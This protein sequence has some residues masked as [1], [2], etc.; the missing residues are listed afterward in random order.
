M[1]RTQVMEALKVKTRL[2][3]IAR[4]FTIGC[5]I[6]AAT[7]LF[8][9]GP[10]LSQHSSSID[11]NVSQ[12]LI[13]IGSLAV[14]FLLLCLA[15]YHARE[16]LMPTLTGAWNRHY[17]GS[18]WR[19]P[20]GEIAQFARSDF[21]GTRLFV[22][23]DEQDTDVMW[24]GDLQRQM[25]DGT[26]QRVDLK[27]AT[28]DPVGPAWRIS[29]L[30]AVFSALALSLIMIARELVQNDISPAVWIPFCAWFTAAICYGYYLSQKGAIYDVWSNSLL[31]RVSVCE[32][33]T[34]DGRIGRVRAVSRISGED[35]Q[36]RDVITIKFTDGSK[37]RFERQDLRPVDIGYSSRMVET[38][39]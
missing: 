27:E 25:P 31:Q 9:F 8:A 1:S 10:Y 30:I 11:E 17:E 12:N 2:A 19:T 35:D 37:Q 5:G 6:V 28:T 29:G 26:F 3:L 24:L 18:T 22:T 16:R 15:A 33:K 4:G 7:N 34:L 20:A 39:P 36:H 14:G 23:F 13:T 32:W 21:T 38:T